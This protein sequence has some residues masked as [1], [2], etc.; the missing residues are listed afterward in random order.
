ML[1]DRTDALEAD[2][3]RFYG[4]DL[5]DLWRGRLSLR[6]L[7]VLVAGL[8]SESAL[9]ADENGIARGW[10][11]TNLIMADVF[12]AF[13][14]EPYPGRPAPKNDRKRDVT[15]RLLAQRARLAASTPTENA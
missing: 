6:R 2:L 13:A 14:G 8:P 11:L 4:V 7:S 1:R 15:S 10:T 12:H 9:W 5:L 3:L